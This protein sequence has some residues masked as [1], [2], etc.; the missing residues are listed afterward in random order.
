MSA[1]YT[2]V[3]ANLLF[4]LH[5]R[6]KRHSTVRVRNALEESQW[7]PR[8]RIEEAQAKR[9]SAFLSQAAVHVPYYRA[10]F[11]ERGIDPSA[12]RSRADLAALPFLDKAAIR[13]NSEALR[14]DNA[15]GLAR[16]NTGGS[17]GEPLVFFI[18]K[19]RVSHDVAAKWRAT[20]WWGV[21]IG[22]PEIVVW[23]SPIELAKEDRV[24][25]LRDRLLR[26]EL[27]PAFEMSEAKLDAF[28]ARIRALRPK[29]LFG[30]PSALAHIARHA[31]S[32]AIRMDDLGIR[33][34]F[35][36]SERLYDDQRA[37]IA[38]TFGC[39]VA[40]GYGGRDAG[41]I[42]HECPEGRM[43]ITAEDIV[44]ETIDQRGLPAKAGEPGEIVVTH[45]ATGD[46]PFI[47]Y[48]TGDIGVLDDSSCP[49]GRGLPLLKEIQGRT[50]DFV[51]AHDGT[52]LHGLA[53]IYVVRDLPG[54]ES[55]KVIQE[56]RDRTR[57]LLVRGE[58]FQ[59]NAVAS[60]VEGFKRR[61][62]QSVDV[63]VEIVDAI[64][65]E[66]SGKFRYIVSHVPATVAALAV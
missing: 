45:L 52:V 62:G 31:T 65:P 36:T 41:F 53:L 63:R 49:C 46:F 21:D 18:G 39:R 32:R 33:V 59:P 22:D 37:M 43:H 24:R 13:A 27:L 35:V 8:Q 30:Y 9:L 20:R 55:F 6:I 47:R 17:S 44:V 28:V 40:N 66:K 54:I 1:I 5:E 25:R 61:L 16:L 14:A 7:W 50:T 3:A 38:G 34:S 29:M 57:V 15:R 42:A 4:P 23:G 60:I 48:R 2:S 64:P 51:V 58:A 11:R 26:T 19:E 12:I 10:L 56:S